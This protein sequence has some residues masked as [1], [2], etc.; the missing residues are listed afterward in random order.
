MRNNSLTFLQHIGV[1]GDRMAHVVKVAAV[2]RRLGQGHV[3]KDSA[4]AL[5]HL[6]NRLAVI[7][8]HAVR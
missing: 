7:M 2:E 3:I 8:A 1:L 5:G 6:L 4:R